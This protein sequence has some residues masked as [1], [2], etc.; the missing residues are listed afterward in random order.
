MA[1]EVKT[2]KVSPATGAALSIG[3]S[4]DTITV[5]SGATL[6]ISASTLTPPAIMPAS[7]GVNLTALNATNLGSGTVPTARLGSGTADATTFL[8]G[9]QTYAAAGG[10]LSEFSQWRL[11]TSFTGN[12]DPITSNLELVDTYG[13]GGYG[14]AMTESSGVFTFPST[15]WWYIGFGGGWTGSVDTFCTRMIYT[16]PDNSTWSMASREDQRLYHSRCS[17][18]TS[19]IFQVASTTLSKVRFV[20]TISGSSTIRNGT[21]TVGSSSGNYNAMT[22]IKLGDL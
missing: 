12:Q 21:N 19:F 2:N 5:P 22:F 15:G 1:S 8:R 20:I 13:G 4:G 11:T 17:T 16:T 3:D 14:S 7:S 18:Y 6:D 10:G 9:D